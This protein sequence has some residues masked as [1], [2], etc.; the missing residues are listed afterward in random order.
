M[1]KGEIMKQ[2]VIHFLNRL[3]FESKKEVVSY[4]SPGQVIVVGSN[5]GWLDENLCWEIIKNYPKKLILVGD[6]MEQLK[7]MEQ[8]T[9]RYCP[10]LD[11]EMI[12]FDKA[13]GQS[14][15]YFKNKYNPDLLIVAERGKQMQY[16]KV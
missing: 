4:E 3:G 15:E 16:L 8:E 12:I 2:H 13:L 10:K 9:K 14:A 11:T 7:H 6:K 1:I 5:N